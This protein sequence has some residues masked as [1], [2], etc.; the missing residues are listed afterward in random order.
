MKRIF[1]NEGGM[2]DRFIASSGID[3]ITCGRQIARLVAEL[4]P[5]TLEDLHSACKLE[6]YPELAKLSPES[7]EAAAAAF[8][9]CRVFDGEGLAGESSFL[10]TCDP[11]AA[12]VV[13][14]P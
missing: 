6:E 8:V 13:L 1:Y 3:A 12:K 7:I 4:G 14:L 9:A 5:M 11:T 2:R 10:L